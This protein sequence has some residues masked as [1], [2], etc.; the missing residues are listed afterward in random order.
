MN[1]ASA[2]KTKRLV[3]ISRILGIASFILLM[4]LSNHFL[5]A[6]GGICAVLGGSTALIAL[7]RNKEEGND[8]EVKNVAEAS[9]ILIILS[10]AMI[11]FILSPVNPLKSRVSMDFSRI[12]TDILP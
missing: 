6:V 2:A 5:Q 12:G 9:L 7:K 1:A 4:M 11:L 3:H 8:E 10:V